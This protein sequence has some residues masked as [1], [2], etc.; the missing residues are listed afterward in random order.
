MKAEKAREYQHRDTILSRR[1]SPGTIEQTQCLGLEERGLFAIMARLGSP[2][3]AQM[4]S[5][6]CQYL[7]HDI[8][9]RERSRHN[10]TETLMVN[11]PSIVDGCSC[12]EYELAEQLLM[13]HVERRTQGAILH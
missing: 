8:R 13:V 10:S 11:T 1:L 4:Q 6:K 5:R 3:M 2:C 9:G 12:M 7:I